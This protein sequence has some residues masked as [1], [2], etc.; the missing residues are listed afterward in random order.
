MSD[1]KGYTRLGPGLR[2][3]GGDLDKRTLLR[4][5]TAL[6]NDHS[7]RCITKIKYSRAYQFP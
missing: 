2:P 7:S 6:P 4:P 5:L 1:E 3:G